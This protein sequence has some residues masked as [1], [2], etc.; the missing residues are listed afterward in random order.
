MVDQILA[1]VW[2]QFRISRNHL[3]R[4]GGGGVVMGLITALWYLMFVGLA[5]LAAFGIPRLPPSAP[6]T[7]L[8]IALLAL[9]L[10]NQTI[11][12]LTLSA[13]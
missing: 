3:P 11:P 4:T 9:F 2:A 1:I 12:L 13:G 7:A 5:W 10:Y 6:Q 8:P